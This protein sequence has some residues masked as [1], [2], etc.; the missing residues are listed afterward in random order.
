MRELIW[1]AIISGALRFSDA[2]FVAHGCGKP[3]IK[4]HFPALRLCHPVLR[5]SV[6]P[7]SGGK[8]DHGDGSNR[9]GTVLQ[10]QAPSFYFT[11]DRGL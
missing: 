2:K 11:T 7:S 10:S 1:G 8:Q 5:R 6:N 9:Q 3:K 4:G